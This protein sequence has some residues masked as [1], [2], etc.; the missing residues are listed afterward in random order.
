S[1]CQVLS[2]GFPLYGPLDALLYRD[3]QQLVHDVA[4]RDLR[5]SPTKIADYVKAVDLLASRGEEAARLAR[6]LSNLSPST[7]TAQQPIMLVH[8]SSTRE[9]VHGSI[10]SVGGLSIASPYT[11]AQFD[12]DV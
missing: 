10:K 4:R 8:G 7:A 2:A 11:S 3:P 5:F 12:F 9:E 1:G 6:F